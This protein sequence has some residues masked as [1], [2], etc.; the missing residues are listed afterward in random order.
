MIMRDP[1]RPR[2]PGRALCVGA[3]TTLALLATAFA[4]S[5]ANA[6]TT[7]ARQ[8][9]VASP[10]CSTAIGTAPA[11][12]SGTTSMTPTTYPQPFGV[13]ISRDGKFAFVADGPGLVTF[14][15]QGPV[16]KLLTD[17]PANNA[18]LF[19]LALSRDGKIL[20]GA[21]GNGMAFF[22]MSDLERG[23]AGADAAEIGEV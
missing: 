2:R 19:G 1:A 6:T 23:Q 20:V 5:T 11:L 17:V 4:S 3:T 9:A 7:A 16:P 8:D 13:V 14:S 21:G 22:A 15:L 12:S 18:P 10:S